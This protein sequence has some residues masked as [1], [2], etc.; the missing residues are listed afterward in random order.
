MPCSDSHANTT[1]GP[2]ELTLNDTVDYNNVTP[3]VDIWALGCVII[4]AAVWIAFGEHGRQ[5]FQRFRVD[6][7]SRIPN[8]ANLGRGD[9]FHDGLTVLE[10]VTE[11]SQRLESDG[12]MCDTITG[13]IVKLMLSDVLVPR[14]ERY[15]AQQVYARMN[16]IIHPQPHRP[17]NRNSFRSQTANGTFAHRSNFK[18]ETLSGPSIPIIAP[19][20]S[21]VPEQST[22]AA[23][24]SRLGAIPPRVDPNT[25]ITP[26]HPQESSPKSPPV[27]TGHPIRDSGVGLRSPL[28]T[29]MIS[30][31][32][33]VLIDQL[34]SWIRDGKKGI[35]RVLPGWDAV[36]RQ[37]RG[38]DFVS[39]D[40]STLDYVLN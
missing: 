19:S 14:N 15:S 12:R 23:N 16:Q 11:I 21:P 39:A 17:G 36:K 2:P 35:T 33:R 4:E 8:H 28:S 9:C 31:F 1:L 29:A 6:E 13:G 5:E 30:P 24:S 38:R 40:F 18:S 27:P 34:E 32:P 22:S 26:L 3:A 20:R 7:T 25:A 10:C 37:L